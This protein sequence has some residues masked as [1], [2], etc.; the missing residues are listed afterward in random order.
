MGN[1]RVTPEL[2]QL[3][4]DTAKHTGL[5]VCGVIRK[6]AIGIR[7]GRAVVRFEIPGTYYRKPAEAIRVRDFTMPEGIEPEEF[8][9]LLAMRCMEELRKPA[10]TLPEF[11]GP[12]EGG[13]II[14]EN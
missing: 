13:Y 8:R 3:L 11:P 7:R 2:H 12:A 4:R 5:D 9:R 1:L 10:A 14:M 6:T